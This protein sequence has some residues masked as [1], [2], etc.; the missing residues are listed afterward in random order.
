M[1][2]KITVEK[3]QPFEVRKKD[4]AFGGKETTVVT[5]DADSGVKATA[6]SLAE[7]TE[8]PIPDGETG[9]WNDAGTLKFRLTNGTDS[10]SGDITAVTAGTGLSGGGTSGAVTL[11]LAAG[12]A[13]ANLANGS[14]TGPK[15]A[16]TAFRTITFNGRNGAGACTAT[17]VKAGD[18]IL[19]LV[20]TDDG[21]FN[22]GAFN[23]TVS[24]DDEIEQV[25]PSNLLANTY[26]A[27]ILAQ[28]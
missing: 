12:A 21:A 1:A 6:L 26:S 23:S 5:V 19:F 3:D 9:I 10:G 28:A 11:S 18:K 7:V 20:K 17:G 14:I 15:I 13:A 16:T 4:R 22:Y 27:L 8:C 25:A 2:N 24:V